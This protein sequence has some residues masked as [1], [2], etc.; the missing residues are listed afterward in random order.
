[1]TVRSWIWGLI[2]G[3]L[4]TQA[5][6]V[7]I[8]EFRN[9]QQQQRYEALIEK[10]RCLVCQNQ[11]LADSDADLARDLRTEVYEIIQAGQT[12]EEALEFLTDRYG[13][14]VLYDPP[15]KGLTVLLWGGPWVFL[16]LGLAIL[17]QTH[18]RQ[19]RVLP[20][21]EAERA[22]LK[23]LQKSLQPGKSARK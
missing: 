14:F 15:V 9:P 6:A 20:L 19:P 7:E 8:R 18:R 2:L 17:W 23:Q 5:D 11:S 12:D 10:L 4:M 3:I 21:D 16:A 1:M 22:R 13:D